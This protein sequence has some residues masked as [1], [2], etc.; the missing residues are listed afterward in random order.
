MNGKPVFGIDVDGTL[1]EYHA[2]FTWFV[3]LYTGKPVPSEPYAGGPFHKYLGIGKPKYREIKLAF[4]QSG[5]KRAMPA[6]PGASHLTSWL[7]GGGAEVV[8]CTTRP[9][10]HLSNIEPDLREWLRRNRIKYDDIIMGE[11]KYRELKRGYGDRVVCVLDD[12][13][14]MVLQAQAAGLP[15]ILRAR[16]Y[17][18]PTNWLS[19]NTLTEAEDLM[20]KLMEER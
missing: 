3:G 5:L 6:D 13:P 4:R 16:S 18:T 9:Y 2:F 10:L 17:N 7:R 20:V 11:H 1:A 8:I 15:S 12:L 19:V 14:E